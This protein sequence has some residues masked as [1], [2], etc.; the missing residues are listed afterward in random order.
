LL[1]DLVVSL[2]PLQSLIESTSED[3]CLVVRSPVQ[4]GLAERVPGL[5]ASVEEPL[6]IRSPDFPNQKIYN[7]RAH[8]LQTDFVWGSP[9]F[10]ERY[11]GFGVSETVRQICR[12]LQIDDGQSRLRP[13]KFSLDEKLEGKIALIPASAAPIKH[14]PQS[15]WLT[16]HQR[17]RQLGKET[18][19]IGEIK[20]NS[21]VKFLYENGLQWIHTPTITDALDAISSC[22]GVVSVDTGLMHLAVHQGI[23]T[24]ALF[25]EYTFFLREYPHA[26]NIVAPPCEKTC[27]EGQ[28]DFAPNAQLFFSDWSVDDS[29]L[30]W[31][32]MRCKQEEGGCLSRIS[33]DTVIDAM[34]GQGIL[35]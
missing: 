9:A 22:A 13:L 12:D 29:Y 4:Q 26:R 14:W 8:P 23:K 35:E 17:L 32:N 25:R 5:A 16:L 19:L 7:L 18:V 31:N 3:V 6:F 15:N 33:V 1:G 11:P 20:E 24:V 21:P 2:P 30:Y 10:Y 27:L 34:I 28:F